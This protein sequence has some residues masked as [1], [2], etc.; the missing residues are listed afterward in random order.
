MPRVS[1]KREQAIKDVAAATGLHPWAIRDGL[2]LHN[3]GG[4]ID[5]GLAYA[6]TQREAVLELR[7][8][9]KATQRLVDGKY[10][11]WTNAGG[12]NECLHGY[13]DGIPFRK[14]DIETVRA[15]LE[16]SK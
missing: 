5:R 7:E 2:D 15:A 16:R 4:W 13:A 12:P 9:L 8:A 3:P 6:V 14:C 11:D 1:D 10:L